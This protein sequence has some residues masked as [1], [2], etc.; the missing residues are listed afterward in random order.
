M[1]FS[2]EDWDPNLI[3]QKVQPWGKRIQLLYRISS[4]INE[5]EEQQVK[6]ENDQKESI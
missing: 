5:F 6:E 1:S 4:L 2:L 3:R